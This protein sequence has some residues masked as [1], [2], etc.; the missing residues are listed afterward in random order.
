MINYH[1]VMFN[2]HCSVASK[3][4]TR[5]MCDRISQEQVMEDHMIQ[6]VGAPYCMHH[7]AKF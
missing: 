5:L 7:P 3:D 1:L 4:I 2:V 6:R